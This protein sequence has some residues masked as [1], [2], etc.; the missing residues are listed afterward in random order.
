MDKDKKIKVAVLANV[1]VWTL[2]GLEHLKEPGHYA[3]WLEPLIPEFEKHIEVDMHWITMSKQINEPLEYQVYGQTFHILPRGKKSIS[4]ATAYIVEIRAIR[5]VIKKLAPE[6]LHAWG[7]E[8]V[9]G[10]AGCFSSI[11]QRIFTLQGCLTDY[12]RL[13]GGGLLFRLQ[14]IYEKPTV[15]RYRYGTAESPAARDLLAEINPSMEIELVDY[16]VNPDFFDAKWEPAPTPEVV[17]LGSITERKGI[18]D[19]VELAKAPRM[20]HIQF[21]ILGEGELRSELEKA[22]SSNV[23][24]LGKCDRDQVIKKLSSAWC[25]VVPTYADTGPTVIKEARVVGLPII[26][27]TGA[28]AACYV[29]EGV[30][31]FVLSPGDIEAISKAVLDV[32]VSREN[33]LAMGAA[34]WQAVRG[35]LHSAVTARK[36]AELYHKLHR[37]GA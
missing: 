18:A 16:G 28:G 13:L 19:L 25:L 34:G 26:T 7:S 14:A 30:S 37:G 5:R 23:H 31:G 1:P 11:K 3:T 15:R 22:S 36:F 21:N 32:C 4:M 9:C 2:P 6:V 8:D 27:T 24:W 29:E 35:K 20:S 10:L 33:A 12:L 17:F